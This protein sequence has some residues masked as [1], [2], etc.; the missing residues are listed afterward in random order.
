M[1]FAR[2]APVCAGQGTWYELTTV[3]VAKAYRV[4]RRTASS[5]PGGLVGV[6]PRP[7]HRREDGGGDEGQGHREERRDL[8]HATSVTPHM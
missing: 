8:G 3:K 5:A 2:Q 4:V 7:D 1:L 6:V